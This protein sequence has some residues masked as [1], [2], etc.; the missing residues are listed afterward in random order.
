M[1]SSLEEHRSGQPFSDFVYWLHNEYG[2]R[3]ALYPLKD[4]WYSL[5]KKTSVRFE[6]IWSILKWL[7][8]ILISK[9]KLH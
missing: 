5:S 8:C 6:N 4:A 1:F 2:E 7:L 3:G 9:N